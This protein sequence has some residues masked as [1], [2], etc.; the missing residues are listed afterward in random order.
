EL[1]LKRGNDM[2]ESIPHWLSKQAELKPDLIAVETENGDMI[3]FQELCEQSKSYAKKLAHLG[4]AKGDNVGIIST[5]DL[6]MVIAIHAL[7]Y[8]GAVFVMLKTKIT[9]HEPQ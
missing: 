9:S 7:N 1:I 5:N 4:V 3:T 8:L 2:S 6:S